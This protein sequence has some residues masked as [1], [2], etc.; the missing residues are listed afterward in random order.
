MRLID[1]LFGGFLVILLGNLFGRMQKRSNNLSPGFGPNPK[2]LDTDSAKDGQPEPSVIVISKYFGMGSIILS[3]PLLRAVRQRHPRARILFVSFAYNAQLLSFIP[4]IDEAICIRTSLRYFVWDVLGVLGRLRKLKVD[5]FLDLEFF[6]RFAVL[7]NWWSGARNRVGFHTLS[8]S[9][10]GRLLTHRI[11]W[12]PYKHAMDNFLALGGGIGIAPKDKQLELK[13][14]QSDEEE[15]GIA[16]LRQEGLSQGGYLI[17]SPHADTMRTLKS[18]PT[19]QWLQLTK[20]LN[21]KTGKSIVF[22]G[23]KMDPNWDLKLSDKRPYQHN[24]SGKTPLVTLMVLLKN[25]AGIISVDSGVAHLS[26]LFKVPMLT[27]FGPETPLLYGPL[28]PRG[29][30]VD[31]QLHCSPCLN[32]LE[33]KMSDCQNNVCINKWLPEQLCERMIGILSE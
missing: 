19:Q 12:N 4:H 26:A 13:D 27:L 22:V 33:G 1:R 11:Y 25:A 10:R 23:S 3:V 20:L 8:L 28:N 6:S 14:F 5:I 32:L 15:K 18:Y 31:P 29:H 21:E 2:S 7:M 17:C 16:W 24:L 30:I 9:S